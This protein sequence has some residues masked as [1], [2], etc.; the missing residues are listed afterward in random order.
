MPWRIV[1]RHDR[2]GLRDP[3]G[4]VCDKAHAW[5]P[6]VRACPRCAPRWGRGRR[7]PDEV[8]ADTAPDLLLCVVG[9]T[10]FEPV[11]PSVSGGSGQLAAPRTAPPCSVLQQLKGGIA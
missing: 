6:C 10:G 7:R 9:A 11:T 4:G 8:G 3:V 5:Q 1:L 2:S